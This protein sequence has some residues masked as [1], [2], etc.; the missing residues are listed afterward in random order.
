M[1]VFLWWEIKKN[2]NPLQLKLSSSRVQYD[3]IFL[4]I[5]LHK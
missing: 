1:C 4:P 3:S 2:M 5:N